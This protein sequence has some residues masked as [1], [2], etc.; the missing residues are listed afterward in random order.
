MYNISTLHLHCTLYNVQVHAYCLYANDL[1]HFL[2]FP[3]KMHIRDSPA[4]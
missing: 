2:K 4:V 1:K 3:N